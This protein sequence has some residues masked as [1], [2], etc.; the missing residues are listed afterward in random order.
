MMIFDTPIPADSIKAVKEETV[1]QLKDMS[2]DQLMNT[3]ISDLVH[4]VIRLAIAIAVFYIGKWIINRL[5]TLVE[6]IMLK[7][8]IDPSVTTFALSTVRCVLY[9][10]L[11]VTIIGIL[12]LETSSFLALFASAGVAIGMALSGTLQNFAG[13]VLILL[14]KPFRVGQYIETQGYAGTVQRIEIFNTFITTGDNKTIILPN[15]A[16]STSAVNNY[17]VQSFRRV[18]WSIGVAYGADVSKVRA[19]AM[20]MMEADPDIKAGREG[21]GKAPVVYVGSLDDSAVTMLMRAWVP[22]DRY[23]DV[24]F[25]FNEKFYTELPSRADIEFPF[26]QMDV[27]ISQ[28]PETGEK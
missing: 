21:S 3:L 19:A 22:S 28:L 4:F 10:I 13:G 11:I 9:F 2:F 25:L 15:G 6:R 5:Y 20:A 23:W 27:H 1:S 24:F 17:S 12:G 14:L 8:T 26:P 16:L 18:E 7:R